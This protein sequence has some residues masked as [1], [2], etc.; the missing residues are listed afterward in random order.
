MPEQKRPPRFDDVAGLSHVPPKPVRVSPFAGALDPAPVTREV[1]SK[2]LGIVEKP[3]S[4]SLESIPKLPSD[5][6][7]IGVQDEYRLPADRL[8]TKAEVSRVRNGLGQLNVNVPLHLLDDLRVYARR[9]K[10]T[11]QATVTELLVQSLE[12]VSSE[13][14]AIDR[15]KTDKESNQS[16]PEEDAVARDL[17][18]ELI[19]PFTD[20]DREWMESVAPI[21]LLAKLTGVLMRSGRAAGASWCWRGQRAARAGNRPPSSS[22]AR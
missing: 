8:P 9:R 7:V 5:S 21:S 17:Y 13:F 6:L 4:K 18:A 16:S 22:P 20:K 3:P 14:L 11:L 19:A 2:S 10:T 1:A 15:E 12:T